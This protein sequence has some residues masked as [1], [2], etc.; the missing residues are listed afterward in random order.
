[1]PIHC[2]LAIRPLA[3]ADFVAIDHA[4]MGCA[5]A[6]QN[7][8]GRLCDEHVYANDLAARL[9]A[10]GFAD[11]HTQLPLT[12]TH[13]NFSKTY[14][15]DLVVKQMVYELKVVAGFAPEHDAQAIHYAA[16]L[17]IDRVK[18]LNFRTAKVMGKLTRSPF[19]RIDRRQVR[20][21]ETRWQPL[22]ERCGGLQQH[23]RSL[24]ADWGAFLATQLYEE[25]LVYLHGG[26]S[27]C[28][29]HVRVVRQGIELGTHQLPCHADK[30]AF[31][32]TALSHSPSAYEQHLRRLMSFTNLRGIQWMNLHHAEIEFVTLQNGRGMGAKE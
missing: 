1:M 8:L 2:P 17:A 19:A 21:V 11:V 25:G 31:V 23:M 18:L 26:E 12:V 9:R 20:A 28:L 32:I 15:L 4:V 29:R 30:I 27:N 5:F 24:L 13:N 16:L 6:S 22:S 3:D 10:E 7:T 14:R